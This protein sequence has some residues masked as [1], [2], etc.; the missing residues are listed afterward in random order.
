MAH[1]RKDTL[2]KS[3]DWWRHLRPFNKRKVA[4]AERRAARA[5]ITE[6]DYEDAKGLGLHKEPSKMRWLRETDGDSIIPQ[7]CYCYDQKGICPYWDKAENKQEQNNGYCWFQMSGDWDEKGC[8]L[9]WDQ[10][11]NCGKNDVDV[12]EGIIQVIAEKDEEPKC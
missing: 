11:K 5:E 3:P 12:P 7:G 1:K 10:C 8:D 2:T 9:L 4:K 6:E